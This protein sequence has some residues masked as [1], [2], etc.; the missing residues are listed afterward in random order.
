MR[1][2]Y[3][4]AE[5]V[6]EDYVNIDLPNG[7]RDDFW[8]TV[9][10]KLP[11]ESR[12]T[13]ALPSAQDLDLVAEEGIRALHSPS[14][15][16][17]VAF[18]EAYGRCQDHLT[19]KPSTL[20]QAG[21][22]AF[23]VRP[24]A[25]GAIFTGS[26]VLVVLERAYLY[27]YGVKRTKQGNQVRDLNNIV[28][29]QLLLNYC[30][31]HPESDLLL[32]PYASGVNYINHNQ[33]QANVKIQWAE[34]GIIGHN[35]S[36]LEHPVET[37]R[38]KWNTIL[39]IDYV[40]LRDIEPGEELFLDYGDEFEEAW[41]RHVQTWKPPKDSEHYSDAAEFNQKTK[42]D[43]LRTQDEQELNPYPSNLEIRCHKS[44]KKNDWRQL[45]QWGRDYVW[46]IGNKGLPCDILARRKLDD[47]SFA[48]DVRIEYEEEDDEDEED[49]DEITITLYRE[50]LPRS[51]I[52]FVD[53]PYSTDIH[54]ESAFRHEIG[55]PDDIFPGVWR[56]RKEARDDT[57]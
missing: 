39:A 3:E 7:I 46:S 53:T 5:E 48:Y 51:A 44:L 47:G 30:M 6:V 4:T 35:A 11:F 34:N 24:L 36:Y 32:C 14:A 56:N 2:D 10:R 49:E 16:R 18:L 54:L 45:L 8:N 15:T 40:A 38:D 26:P 20:P 57:R 19:P 27:M 17:D 21:R 29:H 33:T 37:M 52:S 13:N 1:E 12:T 55:I 43:V 41:N 25:K 28:G 22:G 23:A 31:G 9:V 42:D 50:G